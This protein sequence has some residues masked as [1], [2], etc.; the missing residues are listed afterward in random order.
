MLSNAIQELWTE[1][2]TQ[3]IG[4]LTKAQTREFVY[5]ILSEMAAKNAHLGFD[6]EEFETNFTNFDQD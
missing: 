2:D 1:Y 3:N 5:D 4:D 6:E